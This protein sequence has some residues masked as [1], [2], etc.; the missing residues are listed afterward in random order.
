MA[1]GRVD[2]LADGWM[3]WRAGGLICGRAGL[4]IGGRVFGMA[5]VWTDWREGGW[6]GG[7]VGG[8][9]GRLMD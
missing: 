8:I 4:W 7:K 5:G 6:I 2:G 9:V 3:D 1:G